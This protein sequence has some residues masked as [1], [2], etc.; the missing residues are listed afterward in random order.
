MTSVRHILFDE[1]LDRLVGRPQGREIRSKGTVDVHRYAYRRSLGHA[2][3]EQFR[4]KF[5]CSDR[6]VLPD[7]PGQQDRIVS[8]IGSIDVV[9]DFRRLAEIRRRPGEGDR[10]LCCNGCRREIDGARRREGGGDESFSG[11]SCTKSSLAQEVI[12]QRA[13]TPAQRVWNSFIL[14]ICYRHSRGFAQDFRWPAAR[15]SGSAG[16]PYTSGSSGL[17]SCRP[18]SAR[19]SWQ[20]RTCRSG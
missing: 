14:S 20:R 12:T 5:I 2:Q 9:Q 7:K 1:H 10:R 13:T 4:S 8:G 3:G 18:S 6:I 15:W 19:D 16:S 17:R 11:E